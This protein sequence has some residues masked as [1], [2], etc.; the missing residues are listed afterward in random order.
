MQ[1]KKADK[2]FRKKEEV[3]TKVSCLLAYQ[4]WL[5]KRGQV[6]YCKYPYEALGDVKLGKQKATNLIRQVLDFTPSRNV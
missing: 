5:E 3:C 1:R 6:P 4:R 2:K